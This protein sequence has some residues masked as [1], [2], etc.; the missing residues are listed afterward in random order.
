LHTVQRSAPLAVRAETVTPFLTYVA[1]D[2]APRI[3]AVFPAPHVAYLTAP[4]ARRHLM[5]VVVD[6]VHEAAFE[7][8][9]LLGRL[10]HD[11]EF[12]RADQVAE[13]WLGP[14]P[15][16][17]LKALGR[18]GEA[19]W[20]PEAYRNL[21]DLMDEAD[22]GVI[23][24]AQID[25]TLAKV[26]ILR[27]L[28]APLRV[29]AV[30]RRL[31]SGEDA[32]LLTEA[33]TA[34]VWRLGAR[35]AKVVTRWRRAETPERLFEMAAEDVH[36]ADFALALYPEHPDLLRL[37]TRR[38]LLQAGVQFRNCL[39]GYATAAAEGRIGLYTWAGPPASAVEIARDG[40]YGWRLAQVR[41][42]SN[43]VLDVDARMR[44]VGLMREIGVWVGREGEDLVVSLHS[45]AA[46]NAARPASPSE[47]Q[48]AFD[49]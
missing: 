25:V 12:Q 34:L 22:A 43:A 18:L 35:A 23:L 45:R 5:H 49:W 27:A 48:E 15:Q 24:R 41:G 30:M 20:T 19:P 9:A 44:L 2:R 42:Q 8:P 11:L 46:G 13:R 47:A 10:P 21:R 33:Y 1:G 31:T 4:T 28:P 29:E 32:A 6:A 37:E 16:G 40:I 14:T 39:A 26:A 38:A 3:A 36:P 17:F 7:Q